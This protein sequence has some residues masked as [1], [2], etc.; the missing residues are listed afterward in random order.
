LNIIKDYFA[1]PS[2][3]AAMAQSIKDF[4]ATHGS[5]QK[6]LMSFHGIPQP[7]ADKGDPYPKR[8]RCTAAQI[9]QALGLKEDEWAISFQSRF[10]KQEWVNLIPINCLEQWA[11][12]A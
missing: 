3:I 2:Y 8:C 7:Y 5:A 11:R 4:S 1:H 9:A 6:L 12:Q 10:G